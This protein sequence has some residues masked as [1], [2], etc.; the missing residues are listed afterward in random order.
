MAFNPHIV[1]KKAL[2][3]PETE[4]VRQPVFSGRYGSHNAPD[5]F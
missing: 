5:L 3:H 2:C 4:K 1:L